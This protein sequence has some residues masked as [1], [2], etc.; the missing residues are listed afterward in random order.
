[1]ARLFEG[2]KDEKALW[3]TVGVMTNLLI[4]RGLEPNDA[5]LVR[6]IA[7]DSTY[8][9]EL[10]GSAEKTFR[11]FPETLERAPQVYE[12]LAELGYKGLTGETIP[13]EPEI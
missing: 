11:I 4:I 5:A 8:R 10:S 13:I 6:T 12:K 2:R 3:A 1:M 9:Q 7:C